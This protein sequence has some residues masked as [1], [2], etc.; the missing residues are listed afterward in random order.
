MSPF[1]Q[2]HYSSDQESVIG[3][4][5]SFVSPEC[6][7]VKAGY[8]FLKITVAME[9]FYNKII[10][11]VSYYTNEILKTGGERESTVVLK[12]IDILMYISYGFTWS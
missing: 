4:D 6:K 8:K 11:I 10:A 2:W 1:L 9:M 5:F 7:W 12:G 3:V